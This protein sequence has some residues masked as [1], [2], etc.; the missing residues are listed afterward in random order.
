MGKLEVAAAEAMEGLVVVDEV[1]DE[2]VLQAVEHL[3]GVLVEQEEVEEEVGEPLEDDHREVPMMIPAVSTF[4]LDGFPSRA[5]GYVHR[6]FRS[7]SIERKR[8]C[9]G[10]AR[11][12]ELSTF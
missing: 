4:S 11:A 5:D 2:A 8:R 9:V 1:G 3:V 7:T 10:L 12:R 6:R